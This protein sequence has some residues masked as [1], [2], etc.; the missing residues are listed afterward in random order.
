MISFCLALLLAHFSPLNL[1]CGISSFACRASRVASGSGL[2][3]G[4]L[5]AVAQPRP[6]SSCPA[7]PP[8]P[9]HP[10]HAAGLP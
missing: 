10:G 1:P 6:A 4:E 8:D 2:L 5:S 3:L 9:A 7:V